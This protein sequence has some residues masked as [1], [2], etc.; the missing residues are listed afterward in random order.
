MSSEYLISCNCYERTLTGFISLFIF[1]SLLCLVRCKNVKGMPFIWGWDGARGLYHDWPS[2]FYMRSVSF[3]R[4]LRRTP[5]TCIV[6][7]DSHQ[8][9]S[10]LSPCGLNR[11]AFRT[12]A[13]PFMGSLSASCKCNIDLPRASITSPFNPQPP[14]LR[15]RALANERE[16]KCWRWHV[17]PSLLSP[18]I[19]SCC[20]C[21]I[22]NL[23]AQLVRMSL[24]KL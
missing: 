3:I 12:S 13:Y 19:F 8:P 11:A 20:R 14:S 15:G 4:T 21:Y 9:V 24:G 23:W 6:L 16:R 10:L 22:S 2:A 18:F 5:K 17:S 7:S 1:S